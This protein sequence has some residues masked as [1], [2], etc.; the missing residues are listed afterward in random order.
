M[1]PEEARYAARRKLG[2]P[3]LIR[4]EIY[5]MNSLGFVKTLW[6]DLR[7]GARLLRLNPGFALVAILSLALGIGANTAIFQLLDALVL[8]TLPVQNPHELAEIRIA[9][10]TELRG[11]VN[12]V[13][14]AVTNSLWESIRKDQQAF[15]GVFAWSSDWF[16][17]APSGELRLGHRIWVSGEFFRVLGIQ[18]FLG[19]LFSSADDRRGCGTPG[20]VISY[21]FWRSEFAGEVSVLGKRI[22]VDYHPVEIIGVTPPGF[23][24]LE[25]GRPFEVAVPICSQ[26][27][28][29]DYSYLDDGTMWWLSVM[30]RLRPGW[31]MEG[32]R[33]QLTGISAG[34]FERTLPLSYPRDGVANY[35][36]YRL[37]TSP[38]GKGVSILRERYS[39]P[40]SMLLG[41]AGLVLLIA[42]ANLASL[43]LARASAREREIALRLAL[44]A[45]RGRLIWQLLCESALLA[46]AGAAVGAGLARSL[47]RFLVAFISTEGDQWFLDLA[48][49]W[50]VLGFTAGVAVLTC[51]LFGL[52]PA[53]RATRHRS[54]GRWSKPVVAE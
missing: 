21:A 45:S 11:S 37:T 34:I 43:M 46:T 3:T 8:R 22:S 27:A 23:L 25:I 5:R 10:P 13:Y 39:N 29:T 20:A 6:K 4:E 14:S 50:R 36:S 49:D 35:L 17:L 41:L 28:L 31:S 40:L 52:A 48:P 2:N 19:R 12:I 38:A 9:N 18:P 51:V 42:C 33:A 54:S 24:G 1:P 16:N 26:A 15:S 47:S 44:G 32:A 30:G 53:L 7:F